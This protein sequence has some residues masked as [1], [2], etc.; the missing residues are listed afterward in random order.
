MLEFEKIMLSLPQVEVP[1][2]HHFSNGVY[3]REMVSPADTFLCGEIHKTEHLVIISQGEISV[4]TNDG[5][6]I[7]R[8]KAPCIIIS[9][10]GMKRI[11]YTHSETVWTTIHATECT[12][13]A[14]VEEEIFDRSVKLEER[15][16]ALL[17]QV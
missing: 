13:L 6:G 1:I 2:L 17:C 15:K 8:L 16:E 5:K 12:D 14:S 10:P 9:K 7:R 3:A 11:G 4:L